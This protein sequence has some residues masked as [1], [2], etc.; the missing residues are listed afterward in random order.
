MSKLKHDRKGEAMA[1][2][3]VKRPVLIESVYAQEVRRELSESQLADA[4][5]ARAEEAAQQDERDRVVD[6]D[7]L[8]GASDQE[9]QPG[10]ELVAGATCPPSASH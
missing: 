8:E 5:Q 4:R 6:L 7:G 3:R 1:R 10:R 9:F 2:R